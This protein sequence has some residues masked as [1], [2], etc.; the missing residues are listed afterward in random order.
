MRTIRSNRLEGANTKLMTTQQLRTSG[1][2]SKDY[3]L[4]PISNIVVVRWLD[5]GIVQLASS[6]A[7]IE[8]GDPVRRWSSQ[9]KKKIDV[10]CPMILEK[11]NE[12]MGGVDLCDMLMSIRLGTG[13]W[14]MH[15]VY[16]CLVVSIVNGCFL[17][18]RHMEQQQVNNKN[19]YL[20]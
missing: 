18:R 7:G 1:R 12:H 13:E 20:F 8:E 19:V 2:G 16:Y 6:Y 14:Y 10:T 3:L 15:L 5:N 11:Y 17:Y 4:I 9:E